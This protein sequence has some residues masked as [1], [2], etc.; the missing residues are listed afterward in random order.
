MPTQQTWLYN[1]GSAVRLTRRPGQSAGASSL[2]GC[3]FGT[4]IPATPGHAGEAVGSGYSGRSTPSRLAL[5]SGAR[6]AQF[7]RRLLRGFFSPASFGIN[8]IMRN[9]GLTKRWSPSHFLSTSA[10]TQAAFA[11]CAPSGAP[12]RRLNDIV[13]VGLVEGT[14]LRWAESNNLLRSE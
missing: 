2:R 9:H 4:E 10:V 7:L 8:S 1:T 13:G 11:P 5:V 12:D 3:V 6:S 14:T